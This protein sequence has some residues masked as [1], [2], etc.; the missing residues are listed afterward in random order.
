MIEEIHYF[1]EKIRKYEKELIDFYVDINY[2]Y[3]RAKKCVE[4]YAYFMIH[5]RLNQPVLKKLTGFSRST[6][7]AIL[8][9]L[10]DLK[11]IKT[12]GIH[13]KIKE[14]IINYDYGRLI[15]GNQDPRVKNISFMKKFFNDAI[16]QKENLSNSFEKSHWVKR[17][18][19]IEFIHWYYFEELHKQNKKWDFIQINLSPLVEEY[20]FSLEFVSIEAEFHQ[21]LID[22]DY[23]QE[24]DEKMTLLN[25]Y[26]L[27]RECLSLA[28]LQQLTQYDRR[29]IL[30]RL[31]ELID[32]G[33]VTYDLHT[34]AYRMH[35][36]THSFGKTERNLLKKLEQY[37]TKFS[38]Y[39]SDFSQKTSELNVY[40][41]YHYIVVQLMHILNDIEKRTKYYFAIPLIMDENLI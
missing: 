1:H 24:N 22:I 35:S 26:F 9:E 11:V 21:Q 14:Y 13:D 16:N 23:F 18:K 39:F 37:K 17:I 8:F 10:L 5:K 25:C 29:T 20:E 15:L 3:G 4:I 2:S 32:V 38:Q 12:D 7:S 6:I 41:G 40:H 36:V 28:Q 30:R 34:K 31:D 19:D 27:T 33:L